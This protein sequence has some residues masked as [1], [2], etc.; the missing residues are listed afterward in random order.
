ML[1]PHLAPEL[2]TELDRVQ[3][4]EGFD[5]M[6]QPPGQLIDLVTRDARFTLV[7]LN[8]AEGEVA[9]ES[10]FAG[11]EESRI[12]Y[13]QGHSFGSAGLRVGHV[14]VGTRIRMRA[15]TG[16]GMETSTLVRI[17]HRDDPE[18][19]DR[20]RSVAESHRLRE[21]TE[22]ELKEIDAKRAAWIEELLTTEYPDEAV[23]AQ[24]RTLVERFGNFDGR[25]CALGLLHQACTYGKFE[26]AVERLQRDWE[27]E[28]SYQPPFARGNPEFM[29][30]NARVWDAA[31]ADLALPIPG[32][33]RPN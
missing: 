11:Y 26:A 10:T 33:E 1:H 23:R 20:I 25:A 21:A 2:R 12:W 29:P 9:M 5:I 4:A 3:S 22:E 15:Q 17:V 13:V 19:V 16:E 31:Y 28:W 32:A 27:Q 18:A 8:P 24:V 14:A 30:K 6:S 7:V